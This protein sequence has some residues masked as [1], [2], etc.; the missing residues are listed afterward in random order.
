MKADRLAAVLRGMGSVLV[1]YSGGVDSAVVL[2]VAGRELGDRAVGCIGVSPSFPER[3]KRDALE[4]AGRLGVRVKLVYPEEHLDP[5]YAAN[6]TNRCYFCK[7]AL[8]ARLRQTADAEGWNAV[9]DGTQADDLGDD[10]P[11]RVAAQQNG[12]RSPLLEA[13]M[14]KAD[15]RDLARKLGLPVWEKPAMACLAS[16]VPHGTAVTPAVLN[17]VERAEDALTDLG[18]RQFRARHHGDVVRLEL[19]AAD[20]ARAVE[21]RRELVSR[22]RAAGYKHVTLDLQG[23]REEP[24][25]S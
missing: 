5:N 6:P 18:F 7:S 17:Q 3:E 13:G 8:Y 21:V 25:S 24:S 9:A 12:V 11:G 23:F 16:R 20:L 1:A 10:R 2:A 22:L 15:V 14:G 4:L 19:P